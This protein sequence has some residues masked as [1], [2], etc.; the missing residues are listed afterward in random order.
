MISQA[1]LALKCYDFLI[2]LL[3]FNYYENMSPRDENSWNL[4]RPSFPLT[5]LDKVEFL[6]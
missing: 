2:F 1:Y 3:N 6:N 4:I 5:R